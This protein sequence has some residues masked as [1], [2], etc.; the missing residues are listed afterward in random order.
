MKSQELN[1]IFAALADPTRRAII[2][3]LAKGDATVKEINK[4]F[5]ISAPAITK[6]L[7]VLEQAGLI[8][9]SRDAQKRPCS[10][11]PIALK[12]ALGWLEQYRAL[13]QV[14]LDRFEVYVE[15]LEKN[16]RERNEKQKK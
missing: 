2:A 11:E 5:E 4:P 1:A 15:S 12:E 3:R 14:R 10:L 16:K 13:W 6:H 9:R 7:K 8:K